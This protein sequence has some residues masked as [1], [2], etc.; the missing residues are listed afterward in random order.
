[1]EPLAGLRLLDVPRDR[2]FRSH[3]DFDF[4]HLVQTKP[5]TRVGN[6]APKNVPHG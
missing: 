2:S 5:A 4:W 1:M 6:L 3:I